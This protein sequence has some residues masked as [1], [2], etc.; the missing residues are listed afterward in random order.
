WAIFEDS[1]GRLW[2][3]SGQAGAAYRDTDGSW[4]NV[5]GFSGH[6]QGAQQATVRDFLEPSKDR[7]WIATDGNGIIEYVPGAAHTKILEH[8][9]A[10]PSSLP[11]NSVRALLQD[12]SGNV[13]V[14]TD[15][16]VA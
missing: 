6:P 14:A 2:V 15:L 4:H 10:M 3:G 13:W 12:R 16:G 9:P 1:A 11:G 7:I 5:P 8:D